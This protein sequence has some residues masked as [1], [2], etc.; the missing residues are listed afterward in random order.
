MFPIRPIAISTDKYFVELSGKVGGS[1]TPVNVVL[2][3]AALAG[4]LAY[5][6]RM[7]NTV[8]WLS[9]APST[10]TLSPNSTQMLT[11]TLQTASLSSGDKLEATILVRFDDGFSIPITVNAE[12]L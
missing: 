6:V 5:E 11:L 3:T 12:A 10:G 9:V 7:N 4:S 1:S 8:D 2:T